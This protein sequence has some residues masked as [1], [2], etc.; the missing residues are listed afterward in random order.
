MSTIWLDQDQFQQ[1]SAA[2]DMDDRANFREMALDIAL[3][4]GVDVNGSFHPNLWLCMPVIDNAEG[5]FALTT[6]LH[7][8]P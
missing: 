7:E 8:E 4:A 1:L 2:L 5:Q 6:E 3:A